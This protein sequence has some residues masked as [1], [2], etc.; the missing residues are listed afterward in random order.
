[1]S[2]TALLGH[3][4]IENVRIYLTSSEKDLEKAVRRASGE[5]TDD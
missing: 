5:L 3:E 1:M 4:S 2:V